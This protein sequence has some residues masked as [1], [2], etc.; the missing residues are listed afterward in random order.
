MIY[1]GQAGI[2]TLWR[3]SGVDHLAR[4]QVITAAEVLRKGGVIAVPTDTL[5]G[6]A[7]CAFDQAAVARVFLLKGRSKGQ[8]LPLLL[9]EAEDLSRCATDV[10]HLAWPLAERFWPGAL[11]LVLRRSDRVP[12]IVCG[13]GATIALRVPDHPMPRAI[14]RELGTP[15]TGT[16]ANRSGGPPLASAKAVQKEFGG[17]ID[18]VVDGGKVQVAI[19]STVLDLSGEQP[20]IL[21]H[22]GVPQ[23]A[24]EEVC[25]PCLAL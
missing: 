16:S 4:K 15:I 8:A 24:I 18:L 12:D 11:T 25:G 9:A 22:G 20:R 5:Y 14:A 10:P 1:C 17:D 7:A 19:A 13:G 6:L 2:S 21:R 3:I 23:G